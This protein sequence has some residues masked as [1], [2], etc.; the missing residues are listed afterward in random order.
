MREQR[1]RKGKGARE[2]ECE[3]EE[4]EEEEEKKDGWMMEQRTFLVKGF[5]S[6]KDSSTSHVPLGRRRDPS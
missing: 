6:S 5:W 4:E 2:R 1:S 3:E